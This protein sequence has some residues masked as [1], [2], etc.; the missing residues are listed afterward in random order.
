MTVENFLNTIKNPSTYNTS[1]STPNE[2][3]SLDY[4]TWSQAS[5]FN[6]FLL[7]NTTQS[8]IYPSP[9][10]QTPSSSN[11]IF[12]E[13][14]E[15]LETSNIIDKDVFKIENV[16]QTLVEN[17]CNVTNVVLKKNDD[18]NDTEMSS[19]TGYT[20]TKYNNL[21][22]NLAIENFKTPSQ[23]DQQYSA[24]AGYP[25]SNSGPSSEM[26]GS[27]VPS[28]DPTSQ[29]THTN[30]FQN[31]MVPPSSVGSGI[32]YGNTNQQQG[33]MMPNTPLD[34]QMKRD[35]EA[36]YGHPLFPLL[37]C[38]FEK[39][40]LATCTPRDCM[41]DGSQSND[42]CSSASFKDDL[43]EFSK[44][45]QTK[46][47]YYQPNPELDNLMLQ[48]I[49]VL[50][51]H[52]LELEKVHELCDNFCLRYVTCLKGKM[53]MDIVGDER[54][55]S[56]QPSISP[57]TTQSCSSPA[58]IPTPL[59]HQPMSNNPNYY[60]SGSNTN[61]DSS[62]SNTSHEVPTSGSSGFHELT[63]QHV[64]QEHPLVM[65]GTPANISM[66][67]AGGAPQPSS[68]NGN[69]P[70]SGI[71]NN[72]NTQSGSSTISTTPS[73]TGNNDAPSETGDDGL[74]VCDSLNGDGR[75]SVSS[76]GNSNSQTNGSSGNGKRKVPKVFSKEAITK[77]RAWLFQNL[78]HPYP[79]EEQKR[80]LAN[81]TGLTI[82]QV[83]NWFINARRRIVQPMIDQNNRAGRSPH[84]NVF[85]NRRRK[86]SGQ[87]PGPSP[88]LISNPSSNYSPEN[89]QNPQL[90]P[91]MGLQT[92]YN[93]ANGMF[94]ATP[95]TSTMP[96]FNPTFTSQVFM[97]NAMMNP[98]TMPQQAMSQ[99]FID[100]FQINNGQ[101][102]IHRE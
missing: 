102:T 59:S 89:G 73:T 27:G 94:S 10:Q 62:T 67:H 58:N 20:K 23:N 78:T 65:G 88:D 60:N 64:K 69:S 19:E 24:D 28:V 80:Q 87:S 32:P 71:V 26:Y 33:I 18:K 15:F 76:E 66:Q 46:K 100:P 44:M 49:Q 85:K 40:E 86:S 21:S 52:L 91:Q 84:V 101:T 82:L 99:N 35:K 98:Y 42:V 1:Q 63:N 95:Y 90:I 45:I 92:A 54:S 55:S 34:E 7:S 96:S 11:I 36:I 47:P 2:L 6:S 4:S 31:Q 83:N 79:S 25:S 14:T 13:E 37:T 81:D 68:Q 70:N 43:M 5:Y 77:F 17:N 8:L 30:F 22:I 12:P 75:E 57:A 39:C 41:R 9:Q 53:P 38:L 29:Q 3:N 56:T 72:S 50:R 51:F 48:A 97:P 74:S 61:N 16:N 93:T